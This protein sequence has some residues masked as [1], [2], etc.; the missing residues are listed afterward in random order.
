MSTEPDHEGNDSE[1]RGNEERSGE[2]LITEKHDDA[3]RPGRRGQGRVLLGALI[4]PAAAFL[5]NLGTWVRADAPTVTEPVRIDVAGTD[6]APAM[7]ALALM[8]LAA[9]LVL[10]ISGR[11]LQA[12]VCALILAAGI[13]MVLAAWAVIQDPQLAA[14][15]QV[16]ER[17]GTT[18]SGGSFELTV[19]PWIGLAAGVGTAV[20]GAL[21]WPLTRGWAGAAKRFDRN[22]ELAE[23]DEEQQENGTTS[24]RAGRARGHADEID[25]WDSLSRGEDPT[26]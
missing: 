14:L 26:D 25:D 2:A 11:A 12:V 5:A 19:W 20:T 6:A 16:G 22:R 9:V 8:S 7:T 24:P 21:M 10:R 1:V 4:A 23:G 18:G 17:T 15:T 3:A 13:G